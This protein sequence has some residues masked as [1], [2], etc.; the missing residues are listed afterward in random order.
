MLE[1]YWLRIQKIRKKLRTEKLEPRTDGTMC[2]N[3]KMVNHVMGRLKDCDHARVPQIKIPIHSGSDKMY[4]PTED[5]K[6][7]YWW[8]NIKAKHRHLVI[9]CL[10]VPKGQGPNNQRPSV[11]VVQ[12]EIPQMEVVDN[13]TMDFPQSFPKSSKWTP[14]DDKASFVESPVKVMDRESKQLRRSCVP[15]VKI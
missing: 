3:G 8:P 6:K 4:P 5:M 13:I 10:T 12:P 11:F 1:V 7:L 14:I 15:I 2:L 9:K